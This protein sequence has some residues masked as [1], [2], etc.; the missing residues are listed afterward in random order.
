VSWAARIVPACQDLA[1]QLTAAGVPATL[2]RSTL[3]IPGAWV[4]PATAT[5]LTLA[6]AGTVRVN[7]LL[8]APSA[9]NKDQEALED[10]QGL[11]VK[12]L[13]VFDP[14]EAVDTSVVF[15]HNNNALPAFRLVVDLDLEE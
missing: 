15:P 4:M 3:R 10:C 13:T 6:G 1:D 9:G 5:R 7:V 8:V 11:L 12:A 14:D 2:S